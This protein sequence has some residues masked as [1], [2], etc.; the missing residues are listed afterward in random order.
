M[1]L[2]EDLSQ[3]YGLSAVSCFQRSSW[4]KKCPLSFENTYASR[5]AQTRKDIQLATVIRMLRPKMKNQASSKVQ[6]GAEG[7]VLI[8]AMKV[9]MS[10]WLMKAMMMAR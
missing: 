8:M 10:T 6:N 1:S 5:L 9:T 3:T 2:T 7:R 4:T